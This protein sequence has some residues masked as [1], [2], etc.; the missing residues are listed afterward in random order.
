MVETARDTE[1]ADHGLPG[2]LWTAKKLRQWAQEKLG[3]KACKGVIRRILAGAKL[4]WKRVKKLLGKAKP[5]ARKAH[6]ERLLELFEQVRREE[7]TLVYIDES[8]FH[9][10]LDY[11][12]GWAPRGQRLWK[13]S[14]CPKL[15]ER[16]NWYGAYDF[17]NGE[18]LLWDGGWCDKTR[19]AEFLSEVAKWRA[20][21]G[22]VV[23]I[24]DRAPW[25][26]AGVA[27]ARAEE[28][29]I[30]LVFLPGYSP[31]LNPIERLW[32]WLRDEV[33]RGHCHVSLPALVAACREALDRINADPLAVVD[34]LWPKFDLDPEY[35]AKLSVPN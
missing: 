27:Q 33:T 7:I 5:E 9:R 2:H 24:W 8:H 21:K 23:V 3:V 30:E 15:S 13:V 25:H 14:G 22:K 28:L 32:D 4:T 35:E 11:G 20:G 31:D 6:V 18:C 10:D 29:G 16:V 34:R 17:S 12:Y 19:T 26:I 1:P